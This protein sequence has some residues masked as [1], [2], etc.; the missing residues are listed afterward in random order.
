MTAH[1]SPSLG[2]TAQDC[3]CVSGVLIQGSSALQ[4][5]LTMPG[6]IL[7]VTTVRKGTLL[8]SAGERTQML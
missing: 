6:A 4:G 1:D 2:D 3:G 5:H 8:A 7:V